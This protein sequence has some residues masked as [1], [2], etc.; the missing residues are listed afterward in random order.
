MQLEVGKR[1]ALY[2]TATKHLP[3]RAAARRYSSPYLALQGLQT[4]DGAGSPGH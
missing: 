3:G 4:L 1:K 2:T